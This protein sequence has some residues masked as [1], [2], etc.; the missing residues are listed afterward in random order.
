MICDVGGFGKEERGKSE[1]R[2]GLGRKETKEYRIEGKTYSQY[3]KYGKRS[4]T[5]FWPDKGMVE[6]F[7]EVQGKV[8]F[9]YFENH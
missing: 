2:P 3:G 7:S 9:E 8:F 4:I 1:L 6:H 5:P